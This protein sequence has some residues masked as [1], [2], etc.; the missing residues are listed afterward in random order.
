[1]KEVIKTLKGTIYYDGIYYDGGLD[2]LLSLRKKDGSCKMDEEKVY[3][4][5]LSSKHISFSDESVKSD[6][7]RKIRKR[8]LNKINKNDTICF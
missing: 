2:E 4:W 8:K 6:V 3:E 1:M 7:V 5:L